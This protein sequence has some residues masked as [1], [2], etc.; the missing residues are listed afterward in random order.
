MELRPLS[1]V[2]QSNRLSIT[3]QRSNGTLPLLVDISGVRFQRGK[4]IPDVLV[5][6]GVDQSARW[7]PFPIFKKK[8][9]PRSYAPTLAPAGGGGQILPHLPCILKNF[10]TK[11]YINFKLSVSFSLFNL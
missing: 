11:K 9:N 6:E 5:D 4:V 7:T 2:D 10:Q 8:Y 1:F 3:R